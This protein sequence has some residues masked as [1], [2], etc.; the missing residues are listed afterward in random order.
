MAGA[1]RTSDDCASACG[2]PNMRRSPNRRFRAFARAVIDDGIDI[3]HGHFAH[4]VQAIERYGH[5]IIIA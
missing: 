5:A 3:V 2:G 4:V 1:A